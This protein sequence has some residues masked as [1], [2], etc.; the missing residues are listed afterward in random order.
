MESVAPQPAPS[1]SKPSKLQARGGAEREDFTDLKEFLDAYPA[2]PE[3]KIQEYEPKSY[4]DWEDDEGDS[5]LKVSKPN[6]KYLHKQ[7]QAVAAAAAEGKENGIA[8]GKDIG[9]KVR[10]IGGEDALQELWGSLDTAISTNCPLDGKHETLEAKCTDVVTKAGH[11]A[12][13]VIEEAQRLPGKWQGRVRKPP[14][15]TLFNDPVWKRTYGK[16]ALARHSKGHSLS[17]D[18]LTT[19]VKRANAASINI[20]TKDGDNP[21]PPTVAQEKARKRREGIDSYVMNPNGFRR[22]NWSRH[23]RGMS[24]ILDPECSP[25]PCARFPDYGCEWE[26][27][28]PEPVEKPSI[29]KKFKSQLSIGSTSTGG[30][31]N[32]PPQYDHIMR[33]NNVMGLHSSTSSD[34]FVDGA[35]QH[36]AGNNQHLGSIPG[37]A[38]KTRRFN[39][40]ANSPSREN[41]DNKEAPPN[42]GR[43]II[44]GISNAE[45]D[46]N[47]PTSKFTSSSSPSTATR[48]S[49]G[50]LPKGPESPDWDDAVKY[51]KKIEKEREAQEAKEARELKLELKKEEKRLKKLKAGQDVVK[52]GSQ[53]G[54]TPKKPI[55]DMT[56]AEFEVV[57]S[58]ATT[59]MK[60]GS[61]TKKSNLLGYLFTRMRGTKHEQELQAKDI[62]NKLEDHPSLQLLKTP[63]S[64]DVNAPTSENQEHYDRALRLLHGDGYEEHNLVSPFGSSSNTRTAATSEPVG[65]GIS[66]ESQEQIA[67]HNNAAAGTSYEG[68]AAMQ[69]TVHP[70]ANVSKRGS[71]EVGSPESAKDNYAVRPMSTIEEVA[72]EEPGVSL[73]NGATSSSSSLYSVN[74]VEEGTTLDGLSG[75]CQPIKNNF[76]SELDRYLDVDA[77]AHSEHSFD[78][79]AIPAP[80]SVQK[81]RQEK[82]APVKVPVMHVSRSSQ[83]MRSPDSNSFTPRRN[84]SFLN[85]IQEASRLQ[86]S[87]VG[88]HPALRDAT[89]GI[90]VVSTPVEDAEDATRP[91]ST[92]ENARIDSGIVMGIDELLDEGY[93]TGTVKQQEFTSAKDTPTGGSKPVVDIDTQ[94]PLK[95]TLIGKTDTGVKAEH[96]VD[97]EALRSEVSLSSLRLASGPDSPKHPHHPFTWDHQKIMCRFIHN[98]MNVQPEI[99]KIPFN[100]RINMSRVGSQYFNT[101]PIKPQMAEAKMCDSCGTFCCRYTNLIVTSKIAKSIDIKEQSVREK[102]EQNVKMLRTL[103]PNGIEEYDTFVDC[104]Q[105]GHHVCPNC[106]EKCTESLCQAIVC[107]DCSGP[108]GV[109][110]VHNLF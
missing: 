6:T 81:R 15:L 11:G 74:E 89:E 43:L 46:A 101:S 39:D 51:V 71:D 66:A 12:D 102:A 40:H 90:D 61:I 91:H 85:R 92:S 20:T 26:Y 57:G 110:P 79:D 24:A 97:V 13:H 19:D 45:L 105:C 94:R 109:C 54:L 108:T 56:E 93:A 52:R 73:T 32:Y 3:D 7:R 100:Q 48:P 4:F 31:G 17:T 103:H 80:L 60:D 67:D 86:Q 2:E 68:P 37:E 84:S 107:A 70:Q 21:K 53:L 63:E 5:N 18:L 29:I 76:V 38:E 82:P 95:P 23:G 50:G 16:L 10:E 96:G 22:V 62:D 83:D 65:L 69:K 34:P 35:S 104:A 47:S 28:R 27:P 8:K 59:P 58:V 49:T 98:P 99:P 41:Q 64:K 75:P 77:D 14:E 30:T 25:K 1:V 55:Q 72:A 9:D 36:D 88:D 42:A 87:K 33:G 44:N 78:A 106:A